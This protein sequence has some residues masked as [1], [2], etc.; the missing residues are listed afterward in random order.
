MSFRVLRQT[1]KSAV[2]P[3]VMAARRSEK[4]VTPSF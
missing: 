4:S 3:S 2:C 1:T